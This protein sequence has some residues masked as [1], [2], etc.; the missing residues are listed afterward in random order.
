M[1]EQST[2][3]ANELQGMLTEQQDQILR[4][5]ANRYD[6]TDPQRQNA[7]LSSLRGAESSPFFQYEQLMRLTVP[8][9]PRPQP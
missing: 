3:Q 8:R 1:R 6:I 5:I 9:A 2:Q 7:F 4:D